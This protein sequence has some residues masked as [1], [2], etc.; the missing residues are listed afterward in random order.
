MM[1]IGPDEARYFKQFAEFIDQLPAGERDI[2]R[3]LKQLDEID[4]AA[5]LLESQALFPAWSKTV[6][7]ADDVRDLRDFRE[8]IY[9]AVV[10]EYSAEPTNASELYRPLIES[11]ESWFSAVPGISRTIPFFTLNYDLVVE[12]AMRGLSVRVVDGID[13]GGPQPMWTRSVF[14]NYAE[15][16]TETTVI[17]VKL[18]GSVGWYRNSQ[19]PESIVRAPIGFARNSGIFRHAMIYPTLG[20]KNLVDEPF[21]VN[22]E[23]LRQCLTGASV[24]VILGSSLRDKELNLLISDSAGYNNRLHIINVS[25]HANV[26]DLKKQIPIEDRRAASYQATFKVRL[27]A[28]DLFWAGLRPLIEEACG[29]PYAGGAFRTQP[30]RGVDWRTAPALPR[31]PSIP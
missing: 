19:N 10:A 30:Q 26:G 22:Y 25:P 3:V 18:H 24:L 31:R 1:D 7:A 16:A 5:Q 9:D 23:L 11:F 20:P 28:H 8:K 15:S 21:H 6:V 17:L 14:E 27:D 12:T 2:E 13:F 4:L 29:I